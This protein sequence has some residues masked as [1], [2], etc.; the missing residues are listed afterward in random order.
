MVV[1]VG[2]EYKVKRIH[3]AGWKRLSYQRHAHRAEHWVV[4]RGTG[5]VTLEGVQ[6]SLAPGQAID[7][8]RGAAHR[9]ENP[10]GE[11]LVF[12]EVQRGEYL[13]E[14]DITRLTDDFGRADRR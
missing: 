5:V 3:V 10:V 12:V 9:M 7:I 1:D 14:D 13:G 4:V 11:D 8:P 6:V 2:E